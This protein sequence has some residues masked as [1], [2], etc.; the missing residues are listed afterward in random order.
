[1]LDKPAITM[2]D[3]G[4]LKMA[5]ESYLGSLG[6]DQRTARRA[7]HLAVIA[8]REF[9]QAVRRE[10][11]AIIRSARAEGR[12][13]ALLLSRP[14]HIDPQIHHKAP[15]ILNDFGVDVLTEDSVPLEDNP[16]LANKHVVSLW[17]YPNRNLYA[18]NWACRQP[19][20]EVVQINSFGC[21]PDAI[22]VDEARRTLNEWKKGFTVI[23]VDE[24]ES[25]GSMRLRLRSMVESM[26]RKAQSDPSYTPRRTTQDFQK[27]DRERIILVPDFARFATLPIARPMMDMGFKIEVLPPADRQSVDIGLKYTNNEICYPAIVIIGDVIKA[28]QSGM[29]DP[30]E[31]AVGIS[32]TGG[33]CRDSCYLTLL[34]HG[35]VAAGFDQVPVISVATNFKPLNDQPGAKVNYPEFIYK[36]LQTMTYA[37]SVSAMY[38]ACAVREE[39]PGSALKLA[40]TFMDALKD[41]NLKIRPGD[42]QSMLKQAVRAFNA[43]PVRESSYPAVGIVGEIYVKLN[44]FGGGGVVPWLIDQGIEVILP[45][46]TEYFTSNFVNWDIDLKKHLLRPDWIWALSRLIERP[47]ENYI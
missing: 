45:P 5:C 47:M 12:P 46:L 9:K 29:Y 16:K 14:Y 8:Q 40:N 34:K 1:P 39:N 33:Q 27:A 19:D 22:A 37:D 6:V 44:T 36:I 10:G 4:L 30:R 38:H 2:R 32:Q 43:V 26:R 3:L 11:A 23:R 13:M 18:A 17:Q 24:I 15:D 20:V 25:T 28:L 41:M 7:F 42:L 35:L 21:G 31:V